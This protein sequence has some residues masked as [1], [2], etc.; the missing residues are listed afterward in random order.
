MHLFENNGVANTEDIVD[1][2][3]DTKGI[4]WRKALDGRE[5]VDVAEYNLIIECCIESHLFQEGTLHLKIDDTV[6]GQETFEVKQK[7]MQECASLFKNVEKAHQVNL[8]VAKDLKDL[9]N[10]MKKPEVFA[11]VA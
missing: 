7:I 8:E 6:I 2:I 11:K 1:T 4:A 10:M 5:V 9:A 3:P